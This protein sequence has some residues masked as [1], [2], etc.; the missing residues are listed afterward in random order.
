M[1]RLVMLTTALMLSVSYLPVSGDNLLASESEVVKSDSSGLESDFKLKEL[2]GEID[3]INQKILLLLN[4]RAEVVLE[5]GELKRE[6]SM[7]VYDPGREKE[8]E[9]KLVEINN[10]PLPNESVIKIFREIISACR[11]LQ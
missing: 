1:R 6:N 9:N 2:R 3:V 4:E 8:I 11:A 7:E 10:G 5:I